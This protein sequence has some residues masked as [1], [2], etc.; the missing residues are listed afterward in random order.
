[1]VSEK[2]YA[3]V[4]RKP[5]VINRLVNASRLGVALLDGWKQGI[6]N[7]PIRYADIGARGGLSRSWQ[8]LWKAGLVSPIFVEPEP[9]AAGV[10]RGLYPDAQIIQRALGDTNETRTLYVTRQPGCS[11]LL[12][13]D[14]SP[15]VPEVFQGLCEVVKK[16]EVEVTVAG[17]AF[18]E[19]NVVPE[20]LKLDVQGMELAILRGLGETLAEIDVVELEV[21]FARTYANQPLFQEIYD[22]MADNGFGLTN[23]F[24]FGVAGTGQ[25]VQANALFGNRRKCG[26]RSALVEDIAL[27]AEGGGYAR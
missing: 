23:I 1:M 22:F 12:E 2:E 15:R 10:L 8:V 7:A 9:E 3:W 6:R 26:K 27:R 17:E 25:A 20:V 13:P 24:A 11:S 19:A 4:A 14:L 21:G 16:V 5:Q 18:A